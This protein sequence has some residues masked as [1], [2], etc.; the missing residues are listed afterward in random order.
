MVRL[1]KRLGFTLIELLVVIAIIA[2]L[3][4]LLLP[5]VQQAREAA[6]RSQ[7]KNNL[8][9]IG[10]A[11]HNYHE[12]VGMFPPGNIT[13]NETICNTWTRGNACSWRVMILPQLDQQPMFNRI[14]FSEWSFFQCTR[15][16]TASW[17]TAK[18]TPLSVLICPS[19]PKAPMYNGSTASTNYAGMYA[20]NNINTYGGCLIP[21]IGGSNTTEC[22]SH[23]GEQWGGMNYRGR[24]IA[25]MIDGPTNIPMVGEVY[26]GRAFYS[27]KNVGSFTGQ[28]CYSWMEESGYC[29]ADTSR[30]PNHWI[31]DEINWLEQYYPGNVGARS[32]SSVHLGG[33]H[34]LFGDGGV[35]FVSNGVDVQTWRNN[36][37]CNGGEPVFVQ[38]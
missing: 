27:F 16:G 36:G 18:A 15:F 26:R 33:A 30:P 11:L 29:G 38:F 12:L 19:D 14:N 25:Q 5:A 23:S 37:T 13:N 35:R 21:P 4:A 17:I 20:G 7:C 3:I 10:L 24:R 32:I 28:R 31:Q 2:V 8:K 1:R 6:R 9:Q 34:A 22:P